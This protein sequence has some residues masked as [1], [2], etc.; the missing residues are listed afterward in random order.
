[1]AAIDK[2]YVKS[3]E[4]LVQFRNW[5]KEQPKLK[6]KYGKEVSLLSYFFD[7]WDDPKCWKE[8][9]A[10][11]IYSAPY[12]VDAY[13]IR[14][15]PFD[16]IQKA[17]MYNYGH[18]TQEDINEKYQIV[19]NRTEDEQKLINEANGNCPK[20]PI[21]YWWLSLSDFIV[22]SKGIITMPNSEKSTYQKILDGELYT[23]PSLENEYIRGK[24]FKIIKTPFNLNNCKCNYSIKSTWDI[25]IILPKHIEDFMWYH[26]SKKSKIGTWDFSSEFVFPEDG[27]SSSSTYCP[28]FRSIRRRI[29]KWNLP[30]GTIV[31]L[32]GRYVGE[33]YKLV[34]KK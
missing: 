32:S 28:S 11:P 33:D 4:E 29:Q 25:E 3:Y 2:I 14:N 30:V 26:S 17:L 34:I 31:R 13:I 18:D 21:S 27:W 23:S 8:G 5:L 1:M 22:D 16:Y 19:L 24:H 9:S 20:E 10:H 12:Y 6:D 7:W 15:C